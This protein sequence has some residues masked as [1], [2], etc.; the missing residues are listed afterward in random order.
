MKSQQNYKKVLEIQKKIVILQHIS[1][2]IMKH[3][4]FKS[5]LMALLAIMTVGGYA[6]TREMQIRCVAFYNLENLFDTI[7]DEGKNDYEFLPDGGMKWTSFKYEHKLNNMAYAISQLGTDEDPR[8]AACV[9]VSEVENIGCL[10]DLCRVL[11][12]KYNR[13]YEPILLEG[14]D[15]RGVDV[16]FLY[17]PAMFKPVSTKGYELHAHYADGGVVKSRLQLWVSGYMLDDDRKI[18]RD[19]LHISVNHWPSRYGGEESSRATRDTAAMLCKQVCDSIYLKEPR[20]K[21]IVMGDLNDDP[22]NHSCAVVM[23]AKKTREEVGEQGFFNT[24][25]QKLDRGIGSLAYQGSWNLFDQIFISEPLMNAQLEEGKWVYWKSQIFNKDFL[26]VQEGKDKGTPP[27]TVK[28]GVWQN[29]YADHY[30]TMIYLIK[31]KQ[32]Q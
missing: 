16:G 6:N 17:N 25:W 7:H 8:G 19:K 11:K 3:T 1:R 23:G 22:F 31:T 18:V 13:H 10:Y 26:T 30:P 28:S 14:P 12:E 24:M 20:A 9:G 21:I 15:R 27:R 2:K 29:G 4:F 5:F 32:A